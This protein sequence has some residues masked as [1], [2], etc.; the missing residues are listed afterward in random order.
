MSV[1]LYYTD[2]CSI[3][4]PTG[5]ID[6]TT[7]VLEWKTESGDSVA[8]VIHREVRSPP[9]SED[10]SPDTELERYVARETRQYPTKFAGLHM[11]R[12]ELASSESGFPMRRKAFRWK[13]E[14]DVLYHHQAFVLTADRIIVLTAAAKA[15]HREAVDGLMDDVL[16]SFRA[17]GE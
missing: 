6:R 13:H 7:N 10:D 4:V 15:R 8:L 16:S 11:E 14:H 5:F 2:D 1:Q 17:R 12:D 9:V 3:P